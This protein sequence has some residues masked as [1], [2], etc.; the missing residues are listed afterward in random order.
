MEIDK[1]VRIVEERIRFKELIDVM[2]WASVEIDEANGV[3]FLHIKPKINQ[4]R[5]HKSQFQTLMDLST[6]RDELEFYWEDGFF[7]V[8]LYK[9]KEEKYTTS[10]DEYGV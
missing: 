6:C 3:T 10:A 4:T 7:V 2:E 9:T 1:L 5:I 8:V